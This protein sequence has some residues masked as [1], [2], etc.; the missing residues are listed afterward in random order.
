[1]HSP[2][3]REAGHH[4]CTTGTDAGMKARATEC[5]LLKKGADSES[6]GAAKAA[7]GAEWQW[8]CKLPGP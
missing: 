8:Q 2:P 3:K 1:V 6:T 7:R 5:S 4:D